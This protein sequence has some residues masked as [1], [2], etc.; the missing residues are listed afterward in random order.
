M[1]KKTLIITIGVIALIAVVGAVTY[2]AQQQRQEG[3]EKVRQEEEQVATIPERP[4]ID[5]SDWKVYRNEKYGF[6]VKYPSQWSEVKGWVTSE[7]VTVLAID[8]DPEAFS[9]IV[10]ITAIDKYL[11]LNMLEGLLSNGWERQVFKGVDAARLRNKVGA[12]GG[13]VYY[14]EIWAFFHP[15][16][17]FFFKIIL[18]TGAYEDADLEH[19]KEIFA[20]ILNSFSFLEQ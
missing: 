18:T 17:P 11:V 6:E 9:P 7:P 3:A 20:E 15:V 19:D 1:A 13:A 2:I 10:T 8:P 5:T 16:L 4:E 14:D 12:E